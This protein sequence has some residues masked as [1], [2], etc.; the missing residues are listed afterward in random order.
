[1]HRG[2]S[3]DTRTAEAQRA[4]DLLQEHRAALIFAAVNR[5]IDVRDNAPT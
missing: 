2:G 1:M 5:Q 4:I 3:S